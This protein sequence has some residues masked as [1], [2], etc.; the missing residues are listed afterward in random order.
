MVEIKLLSMYTFP[1]KYVNKRKNKIKVEIAKT[2]FK[3]NKFIHFKMYFKTSKRVAFHE[4]M[5]NI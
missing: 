2:H 5:K 3:V 4:M 1:N